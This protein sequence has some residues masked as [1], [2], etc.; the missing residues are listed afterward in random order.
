[1]AIR[2]SILDS[3]LALIANDQSYFTYGQNLLGSTLHTLNDLGT[4]S[5]R[6]PQSE[7]GRQ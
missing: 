3:Q 7:V 6:S 1:M 2:S 5:K 4:I